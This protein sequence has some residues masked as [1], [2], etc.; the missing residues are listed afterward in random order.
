MGEAPERFRNGAIRH[1]ADDFH[2]TTERDEQKGNGR[3]NGSIAVHA[4]MGA[5]FGD[6]HGRGVYPR[7]QETRARVCSV[8]DRTLF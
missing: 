7:K 5:V 6:A 4:A 2:Y 3:A 1:S 8:R